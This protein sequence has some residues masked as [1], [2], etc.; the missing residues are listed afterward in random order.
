MSQ[1][2]IFRSVGPSNLEGNQAKAVDDDD[3]APFL[4]HLR[5]R[6]KTKQT[7]HMTTYVIQ[8]ILYYLVHPRLWVITFCPLLMSIVVGLVSVITL[9]SV[10]LWPQARGLASAGVPDGLAWFLAFILVLVE[11]FLVT[12]IYSVAVVPCYMDAVF[13]EVLKQRGHRDLVENEARHAGCARVC[14][15]CCRVSVLL[16]LAVLVLT[17]P[18]H[19]IPIVGTIAWV[20]LNG[21][22]LAW[23]YHL[24]YFELKSYVYAEQKALVARR[25][26]QYTSFGMQAMVLEMVPL[27][28]FVFL[29]TNTVGAAL[30]AAD[31][32]D[33]EVDSELHGQRYP[34]DA[35]Q[36]DFN[37]QKIPD[38][39]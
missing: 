33:D 22:I 34:Q 15:S 12:L 4:V 7:K 6:E 31:M 24:Y 8:G 21:Y 37:K 13:A 32:E 17:L 11:I 14:T 16:R 39:V 10:G 28:G 1:N 3:E 9:F 2:N 30:W 36:Q 20:W 25:K 27:V 29:F 19:L 23:E 18:L 38:M 35:M 26:L 5:Y